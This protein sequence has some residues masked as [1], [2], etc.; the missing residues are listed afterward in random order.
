MTEI[1]KARVLL[2]HLIEHTR[3]HEE[4]FEKWAVILLNHGE[5]EAAKLLKKAGLS[6][7]DAKQNLALALEKIGGPLEGR[8]QHHHHHHE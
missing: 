7:Q 6:L 8:H 3:N 1:E 4:E 2:P 5:P